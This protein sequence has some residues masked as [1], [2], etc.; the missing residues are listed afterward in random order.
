MHLLVLHDGPALLIASRVQALRDSSDPPAHCHTTR[1]LVPDRCSRTEDTG[2]LR[3]GW[4]GSAASNSPKRGLGL[5]QTG[6]TPSTP[7][8]T[9]MPL[10]YPGSAPPRRTPGC[11][12]E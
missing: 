1:C 11:L 5:E 3:K 9:I 8:V 2:G 7:H 4:R 12:S 6:C 10:S